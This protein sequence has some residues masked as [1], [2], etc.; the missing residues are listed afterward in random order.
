[1]F[2][3][4]RSLTFRYLRQKWDRALLVALSIALGVA[5]LVSARLL[6]ECVEQAAMD[7]TVP[8]DVAD[9]YVS[10]GDIGVDWA[11]VADL[12]KA[13]LPGVRRVEPFVFDR[14][15]MPELGDKAATLFGTDLSGRTADDAA[16]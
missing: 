2:S 12:K 10:N 9:L 6:N 8:A 1:M 7:T 3:L 14:I 15:T 11:V 5:T 13:D 16:A 4:L